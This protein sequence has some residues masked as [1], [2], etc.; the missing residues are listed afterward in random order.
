MNQ[1]A[2]ISSMLFVPGSKP[3]RFAK[4]VASG[5]SVACI[6]LEDAVPASG[7][8]LARQN[9]LA[10]IAAGD[11]RLVLRINAI[12]TRAGLEDVLAL[13]DAAILP[14]LL[15]VPMVEETAEI[16]II[17]SVLKDAAPPIVPLIETVRGLGNAH[18]IATTPGVAAMMFGGGDFSAELG[19]ELAWEPLLAARGA[20]ILAC[21]GA[22]IPAIDVP[23]IRLDD[24]A[25]LEAEARAAKALGFAAKA[26]IHPNQV[27]CINTV[28]RPTVEEIADAEAACAAFA[29]ADGA[30]VRFKGRMLEA[31][32]MRRYQRILAMRS[33]DN[34]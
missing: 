26:A 14:A 17:R 30:A 32:I 6:D 28:F 9:A 5:A 18:A 2:T 10:A 25:G 34:A 8:A 16:H 11:P 22:A 1:A 27:E 3:E 29:E 23:Y 19:V 21:A 31:P 4:A 24:S 33:D 12:T 20:F 15:F 13:A 7:K